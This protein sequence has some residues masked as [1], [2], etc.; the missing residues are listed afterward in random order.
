MTGG[1]EFYRKDIDG[2]RA[3][4]ILTVVAHHVRIPGFA[5]GFVGVDV[6]FVIS[7]FLIT[8]ILAAEARNT[9][10]LSLR[11]FYARR[12]RRL[13]PAMVVVVLTTC[14]L[15][16][17]VLLPI[18]GQQQE[19]WRSAIATALYV[20]NFYFWL[21]APGYFDP[22]SDLMPLL[23]TWSLAVE[24]QFYLAWPPLILAL[25]AVARYAHLDF[26]KA[27]VMLTVTILAVSLAWCLW[28][29]RTEPTAAFYLLPTRAWELGTGAAL[30]LWLPALTSRR[31]TRF[32]GSC[33]RGPWF[34]SGSSRIPGTSGIGRC[35]RSCAPTSSRPM[36]RYATQ[37]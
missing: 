28:K 26:Q 25:V 9:G 18:F 2:L 36:T 27:L 21:Y 17:I 33:R 19:L 10:T 13:F 6:F 32:S 15:G 8:S 30:A 12:I 7:G 14:L 3:I 35:C 5:G 4:A 22:S 24:E 29:T 23:H 20:S 34:W 31:K 16:A 37:S 11:A 1:S